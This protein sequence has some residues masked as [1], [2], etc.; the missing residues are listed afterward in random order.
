[1]AT[2]ILYPTQTPVLVPASLFLFP[3]RA[4]WSV[5]GQAPSNVST[6]K[7]VKV[8]SIPFVLVGLHRVLFITNG[9][10]ATTP[11]PSSV[12]HADIFASLTGKVM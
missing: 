9:H 12:S 2:L 7:E 4:S 3:L 1:V 8:L 10:L 5:Q 6:N 11:P